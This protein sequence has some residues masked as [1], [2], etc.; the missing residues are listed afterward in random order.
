MSRYNEDDGSKTMVSFIVGL[1][2]GGLLVWA[3]SGPTA[4]EGS[5]QTTTPDPTPRADTS[6]SRD[7]VD[8]CIDK[9]GVPITETLSGGRYNLIDCKGL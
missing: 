1:L 9:G 7:P 5:T 8:V 3:F 4:P 6:G 2:I